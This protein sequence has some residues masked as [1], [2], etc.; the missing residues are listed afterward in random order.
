[1][2]GFGSELAFAM[3]GVTSGRLE[4]GRVENRQKEGEGPDYNRF[5]ALGSTPQVCKIGGR[6]SG[7]RAGGLQDEA[8]HHFE[9]QTAAVL[10]GRVWYPAPHEDRNSKQLE[11]FFYLALL[12]FLPGH[13]FSMPQLGGCVC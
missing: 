8:R 3:A 1:M 13:L 7:E 6:V 12:T 11:F 9:V 10:W 5:Y 2:W 4:E